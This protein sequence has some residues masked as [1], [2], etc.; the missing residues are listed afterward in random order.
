MVGSTIF[1]NY[2]DDVKRAVVMAQG[3]SRW[4]MH[5]SYIGPEHLL[6][7]LIHA[8]PDAVVTVLGVRSDEVRDAIARFASLGPPYTSASM[9]FTRGAMSAL[10]AAQGIARELHS[11]HV[12][13]EHLLF[14]V[15]SVHDDCL[16][17]AL[18]AAGVDRDSA[19]TR[20]MAAR[21]QG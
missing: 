12:G 17:Q 1:G 5:D 6:L 21:T 19:Q 2:T 4:M 13:I 10:R 8:F 15:L 7:G 16:D 11:G 3:E 20:A 18:A 9:P 14:G